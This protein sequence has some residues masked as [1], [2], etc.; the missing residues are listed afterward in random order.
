[1]AA[2]STFTRTSGSV[3]TSAWANSL[4]DHVVPYTG[5][6][7]VT[8]EG[9]IGVNT[10][11]DRLVIHDGTASRRLGH[12]TASGRTGFIGVSSQF[13]GPGVG[14]Q[15]AFTSIPTDTD[16]FYTGWNGSVYAVTI[17]AAL[18]GIYSVGINLF[19]NVA[20]SGGA[21]ISFNASTVDFQTP[22]PAGRNWGSLGLV[23]PLVGGQVTSVGV[24]NLHSAT[25]TFDIRLWLFRLAI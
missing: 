4:R 12:Y 24:T 15:M 2:R 19:A 1:M 17:P 13:T 10:L 25:A 3:I 7:D 21:I 8:T 9:Q 22:T 23:V 16:G 6:D 5:A 11:T 18:G 14:M 20:L